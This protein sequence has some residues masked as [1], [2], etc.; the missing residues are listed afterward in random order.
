MPA[1]LG[2][3]IFILMPKKYHEV[4][5]AMPHGLSVK[6]C[7]LLVFLHYLFHAPTCDRPSHDPLSVACVPCEGTA[8]YMICL[9]GQMPRKRYKRAFGRRCFERSGILVRTLKDRCKPYVV[10]STN[11]QNT[12]LWTTFVIQCCTRQVTRELLW[13]WL[14]TAI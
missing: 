9:I 2:Y 7:F 12:A 6:K 5:L 11:C 4:W 8:L 13:G 10:V 3:D 1:S 14:C